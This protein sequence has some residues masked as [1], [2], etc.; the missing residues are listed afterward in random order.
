MLRKA[1]SDRLQKSIRGGIETYVKDVR[2]GERIKALLE[3]TD[4]VAAELSSVTEYQNKKQLMD[5]CIE[6][7]M[8]NLGNNSVFM[9]FGVFQGESINY[10]AERTNLPVYGFDSFEGLPNDWRDGFSKGHFDVAKLP[11]VREN[12]KLV[13]G[14]FRDSLGEFDLTNIDP[15]F[16]HIDCDLYESTRDV[17]TALNKHIKIGCVLLFDEFY[18][19]PGWKQGEYKAWT[20]FAS[21]NNISFDYIGYVPASEQVALIIK[22]KD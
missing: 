16:I 15:V 3:S 14:W 9:E 21:D 4:F 8:H 1:I 5:K 22:A 13:K 10:M 7:S 19:Y 11:S 20:E 12:V 6:L 2:N 17:F 18:N